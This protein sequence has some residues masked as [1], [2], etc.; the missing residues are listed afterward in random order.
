MKNKKGNIAI[1]ITI[2]VVLL[3]TIAT[4][5]QLY[6]KDSKNENKNEKQIKSPD[7]EYITFSVKAKSLNVYS[8]VANEYKPE[9][10]LK[11]TLRGKSYQPAADLQPVNKS[12]AKNSEP[13]EAIASFFSANKSGDLDWITSM[14]VPD[15]R[16]SLKELFNSM[17]N[18]APGKTVGQLN[19]EAFEGHTSIA[20]SKIA[21][22]KDFA[23]AVIKYQPSGKF[24]VMIVFKKTDQGWFATN[25]FAQTSSERIKAGDKDLTYNIA[26][27]SVNED[28]IY[29][30]W[31]TTD[32]K[33]LKI[34]SGRKNEKIQLL[35]NPSFREVD[36]VTIPDTPQNP[37][38]ADVPDG[39]YKT[40]SFEASYDV[41]DSAIAQVFDRNGNDITSG[42]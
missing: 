22:Y 5:S 24:Q 30:L 26:E 28:G 2:I 15:E 41:K 9:D 1:Y 7:S 16:Q 20:V 8:L 17:S 3:V 31:Q 35:T 18:Y 14:W 4:I 23:F 27:S 36:G 39:T 19:K 12:D 32:N 6:F 33:V 42:K 37:V 40:I 13:L 38:W 29:S 11:V 34:Y 10:D 21:Y 25:H